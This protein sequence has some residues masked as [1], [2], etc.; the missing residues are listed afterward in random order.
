MHC[1]SLSRQIHFNTMALVKQYKQQIGFG[2]TN[3]KFN[4][5]F[6]VKLSSTN[7]RLKVRKWKDNRA[8][9]HTTHTVEIKTIGHV[10]VWKFIRTVKNKKY[11]KRPTFFEEC[12]W[13]LN[14]NFLKTV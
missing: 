2:K 12:M 5:R 8:T 1:G 13:G 3:G 4:K 14:E 6:S 9:K 10:L 7:Y 11:F